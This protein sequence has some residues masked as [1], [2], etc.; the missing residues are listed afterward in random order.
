MTKPII[1]QPLLRQAISTTSSSLIFLVLGFLEALCAVCVSN[2]TLFGE[3]QGKF[4]S[5]LGLLATGIL[6]VVVAVA[7]VIRTF[8]GSVNQRQYRTPTMSTRKPTISN[9]R[10]PPT[11][12]R[13]NGHLPDLRT[14]E[15]PR[16][17]LYE[18]ECEVEAREKVLLHLYG[19]GSE[20]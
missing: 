15:R 9:L 8:V 18:G 13:G 5:G 20:T 16:K 4:I 10:P 11:S 19:V 14:D 12:P 1:H 6:E 3:A 2:K 7:V 17:K